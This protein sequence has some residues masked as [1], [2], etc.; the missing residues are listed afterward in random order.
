MDQILSVFILILFVRMLYYAYPTGQEYGGNDGASQ[1]KAVLHGIQE[2]ISQ[3]D[4]DDQDTAKGLQLQ[5]TPPGQ[6]G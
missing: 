5:A 1:H 4:R 3:H 2:A 6:F